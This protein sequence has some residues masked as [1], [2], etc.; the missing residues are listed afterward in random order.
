MAREMSRA[1]QDNQQAWDS[2]AAT[3]QREVHEHLAG[4][5]RWG[6]LSPSEDELRVLGDVEA[7]D[8]LEVGSGAGQAA[9]HLA[10]ERGARVT[11]VDLSRAQLDHGRREAA[12][13]GVDARFLEASAEDLRALPDERFDAV[14]SIYAYGFVDD[15]DAAFREAH[16]VLRPGG[17]F[18]FSWSSP[19]QM[20]TVYD[21]AAGRV[22][23][24]RSYFDRANHEEA[25]EHGRVV[26]FHRTYG[27]WLG[28]LVRAGFVVTDIIEPPVREGAPNPWPDAFPEAKLRVVPGTTVWRAVKPAAGAL[29]ASPS[30]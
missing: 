25:D 30:R 2:Y 6:P 23:F 1:T 7:R 26:T 15:L 16:R 17:V 8:V 21:A 19:I 28:A 5:V 22:D 13:L 9:L 10:S 11:C 14:F 29:S 18:A 4:D 20:S 24:D 27:D 12:R 3:Y